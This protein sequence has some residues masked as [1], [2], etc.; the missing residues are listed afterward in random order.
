MLLAHGSTFSRKGA[1]GKFGAVQNGRIALAE[2]VCSE[3]FDDDRLVRAANMFDHLP[4][5]AIPAKAAL[6]P[7]LAK[8]REDAMSA[9]R[10]LPQSLERDQAL[11]ALGR[12]GQPS[13]KSRAKHR[14]AIVR[15]ACGNRLE[16]IEWVIGHAIDCRNKYVHGAE[17]KFDYDR[18]PSSVYFLVTTLEFVYCVSDLIECGWDMNPWREAG[19]SLSHPFARYLQDYPR[20]LRALREV[21]GGGGN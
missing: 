15:A 5:Y 21:L 2:S 18:Y 20:R 3:F 16:E 13:M 9:F 7:A 8:A 1:S 17:G 19:T 11:A 12:L 4:D 14:A 6:E 10:A